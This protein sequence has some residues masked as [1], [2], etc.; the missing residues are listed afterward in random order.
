MFCLTNIF[1]QV[2]ILKTQKVIKWFETQLIAQ[3]VS[4]L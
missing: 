3:S 4:N 2:F 1:Q